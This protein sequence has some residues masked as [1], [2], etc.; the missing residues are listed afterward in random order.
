MRISSSLLASCGAIVVSASSLQLLPPQ[1]SSQ[2]ETGASS[3]GLSLAKIPTTVYITKAL[4]SRRDENGLTLIP[5]SGLEFAQVFVDDLNELS[6]KQKHWNWTLQVVDAVPKN[7]TGVIL[8]AL[9]DGD[10]EGEGGG[11]AQGP[12]LTYENGTPTEEGYI[13]QVK[14]NRA[15]ISGAGARGAF[16]GTRTLLQALLVANWTTLPE[17][18]ARDAPAYATRG[19]M[20]DAG[21]KWY[22]PSFLAELCTYA[23]FFKMSEF[24]YHTSDNYPLNRGHN[25]TWQDVYSQFSLRPEDEELRKGLVQRE[26]ETL[27]RQDFEDLQAH[28]AKR[29]V[30]VVPEIEA[31]GHC[32]SITK[33]KP[34]LALEKKDLLNLTHPDSI[35]TVKKIWDEFLPWFKSKEVHIGADEYNASLADDYIRFV[36]ELSTYINTTSGKRVRIWG[37][38]EPASDP[39]V[40]SIDKDVVVQ[41]WQY[42]QSDPVALVAEGYEVINTEDW[43]AY[44]SLKND[45]MPILPAPYPQ[46]FNESRVLNF[47]DR[48]GWQ[49]E[50]S[51][52]NP[53]NLTE[54]LNLTATGG[55]KGDEGMGKGNNKGAFLA[56]WND[57]GPDAS[58]QLEAYY[59]MRRGIPLVGARAWSGRRGAEVDA[60]NVGESI[61][62]LARRAPGQNLDRKV[63]KL[64]PKSEQA[65]SGSLGKGMKL[66]EWRRG[67][68]GGGG[69]GDVNLGYG[70]K[71][72][73]YTLDLAV[74]GPFTLAAA[75]ADNVLLRMDESGSLV[76]VADGWEYPLRSVAEGDEL[77]GSAPGRIWANVTSST[78]EPLNLTTP[79][80]ITI[81]GDAIGGS[82]V[83]ANGTFKGRFEVYVFGG[84]N[85][86][87]SWSQMAFVAPVNT[88]KGSGV[89]RLEVVGSCLVAMVVAVTATVLLW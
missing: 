43:W 54:Q 56:A 13:L 55:G 45:H 59:A 30:T 8:Q 83:W 67:V 80:N 82:R 27:S 75:E 29:G 12:P 19:F 81:T 25:A 6:P 44:M 53:V 17:S 52:I 64:Q 73:N 41:H 11:D 46:F 66:V 36:N 69:D 10:S 28:C 79:V 62:F 77:E 68:G 47:G 34:E 33:W 40:L 4:A 85:T 26:N 42:G 16:W 14:A 50:P 87:F 35:P 18:H 89:Q 24:H 61:E 49:W 38:D 20:L 9:D 72:I 51:L 37:T 70:S 60:A 84:K 57:N 22:S 74:T 65:Q 76:F 5:P 88:L 15:T 23:S 71:G 63:L 3:V 21:R 32:L 31:P 2:N 58:T 7:V 39:A 1:P 48:A 86:L 78:H